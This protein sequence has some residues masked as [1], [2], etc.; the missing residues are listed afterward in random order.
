MA[1]VSLV[2][3]TVGFAPRQVPGA[4]MEVIPKITF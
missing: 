3:G 2:A 1:L 4:E